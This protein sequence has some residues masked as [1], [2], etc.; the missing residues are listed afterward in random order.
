[1]SNDL[2]RRFPYYSRLLRLY[3][4]AFQQRYAQ[5]MLQTLADMLDDPAANRASIWASVALD[6]PLTLA[7]QQFVYFGDTMTRDT[8]TY[9]KVTSAVSGLMLVPFI[10]ALVAN[11]LIPGHLYHSWPWHYHILLVWVFIL[12]ALAASLSVITFAVWSINRWHRGISFW[13][14][15]SDLAHNWPML[16]FAA[17]GLFIVILV[18]FHDSVHCIIGNPIAQLQNWRQTWACI[19]QR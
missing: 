15:A 13:R 9:I 6:L 7:H 16:L 17:A 5:P 10:T 4:P 2:R 18:W 8:P 14:S 1:V 3:P 12:P 19:A 11:A